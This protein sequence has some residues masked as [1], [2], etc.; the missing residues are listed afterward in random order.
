MSHTSYSQILHNFTISCI[1]VR[2]QEKTIKTNVK[3]DVIMSKANKILSVMLVVALFAGLGAV[4]FTSTDPVS[5]AALTQR[6]GRGGWGGNGGNYT[7]LAL[8]PLSESEAQALQ[9]AILEEYGAFNL[10]TYAS[11]QFEG[12]I[13]FAQIALSEQQHINALVRQAEKYGVSVPENPG[14]SVMPD[15][16]TITE[17]CQAGVDAEI[18]DAAL[19]DELKLVTTHSDLIQVYDRLQSA[20]LNSHLP[21]FELCN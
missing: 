21:A 12:A 1:Q 5:A 7:G 20:S 10:Y 3:G 19:Y 18:A 6:G 14:L 8:E 17:A 9:K 16:T 4:F 13:P 2:W 15:F 11:T